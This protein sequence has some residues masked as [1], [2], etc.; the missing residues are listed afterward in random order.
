MPGLRM[1][2][3]IDGEVVADVNQ[4]EIPL[5]AEV[6]CRLPLTDLEGKCINLFAKGV[7]IAIFI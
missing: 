4:L 3:C 2:A 6:L 1:G 5:I 7:Y